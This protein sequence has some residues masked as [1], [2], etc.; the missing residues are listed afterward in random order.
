MKSVLVT[1]C[2]TGIGLEA[3]RTLK[4]KGYKVI[5]SCRKIV[6]C[7]ALRSEG[8]K[9]VIELDLAS[10]ESIE[11]AVQHIDIITEGR[12]FALFNNGAFGIPGAVEDLSRDALR[13]QFETNVFGTHE[14]TC[15]LLP[16]L[17]R[18]GGSRI[19]QNSSVLGFVSVKARGAYAASKFALEALSDAMRLELQNTDVKISI[20]EPGPIASDFRKNAL[21]NFLRHIDVEKSRCR[22]MYQEV[23]LRLNKQGASTK[24]TLPA[25]A[26]V[27]SLIHALESPK[28]KIRYHVTVQTHLMGFLT[29]V[30]PDRWLDA[31]VGK[32]AKP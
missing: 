10:T 32:F 31:F 7:E 16:M 26:V 6:D 3:A 25:S 17:I 9:H 4:A 21:A 11:K 1:G 27:R 28:P 8:F 2:S 24:F 29:R 22:D 12:L 15:K 19:V 20:I 14:L 23:L 30:L 18:H 5:A 13:E